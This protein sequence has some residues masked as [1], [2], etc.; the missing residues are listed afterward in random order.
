MPYRDKFTTPMSSKLLMR[1]FLTES[2]GV[3][4]FCVEILPQCAWDLLPAEFLYAIYIQHYNNTHSKGSP[5]GRNKFYKEV[6]AYAENPENEAG[7]K[8][9]NDTRSKGRM[10]W[11]EPLLEQYNLTQFIGNS[12]AIGDIWNPTNYKLLDSYSGLVRTTP[13]ANSTATD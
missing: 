2:N 9:T 13:S 1:E 11:E 6:R 3:Y 5:I 7:F 12:Y 4:A 8:W 10:D